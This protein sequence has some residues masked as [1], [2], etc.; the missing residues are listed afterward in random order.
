MTTRLFRNLSVASIFLTLF[1]MLSACATNPPSVSVEC[2][3][4]IKA[5][6]VTGQNGGTGYSVQLATTA[7]TG[8]LGAI[9]SQDL[10]N[11]DL[12]TVGLQVSVE[13][14]QISSS[15]GT[16]MLQLYN[17]T[18]FVAQK[19]F[20]YVMDGSTV[21]PTDPAAVKSWLAGYVGLADTVSGVVDIPITPA[22]GA[23]S[24]TATGTLVENNT[25]F[26]QGRAILEL[27]TNP[28]CPPPLK[29]CQP[30]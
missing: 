1:V 3:M 20:A 28:K 13:G 17:G 30:Q 22:V 10:D 14:A 5:N 9:T 29:D 27:E 8:S 24:I 7:N 19:T 2:K 25:D 21:T 15:T 18:Q 23:T 6:A 12:S 4:K 11:A 26:V 16:Y